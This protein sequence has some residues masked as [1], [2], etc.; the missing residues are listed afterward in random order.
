MST[1]PKGIKTNIAEEL[2]EEVYQALET[3]VGSENV[4]KDPAICQAYARGGY[5]T[6]LYDRE[7]YPPTCVILPQNTEE[8]QAIVKVANRYK[9]P[10][11]PVSTYYITYATPARPN[12]IMMDLKRMNKLITIDEK[13]MYAIVEPY[14][15]HSQIQ[16]EAWKRGL[17]HMSL[18]CGGQASVLAN[19]IF[20]GLGPLGYRI[21]FNGARRLMGTEWV[22]PDGEIV[23][24]GSTSILREYFWG[25]GPGPDLRG[26]LRGL[27]GHCGG[28]GV[29][30][31][32][33]VKLFPWVP[34]AE[35]P[36]KPTGVTPDATLT[37]PQNRIKWYNIHYSNLKNMI[38]AMY[39]ISKA[40]IGAMVHNVAPLW[41]YIP[42]SESATD[43]YDKWS[44]EKE[45]F[46]K[47]GFHFLRVLLVGYTS[48]KQ[49]EYEERV[50][51]EIASETG[52]LRI[53]EAR[54]FDKSWLI[55]SDSLTVFRIAGSELSPKFVFDSLDDAAKL[56]QMVGEFRNKRV[57]PFYDA[58]DYGWI[59]S[60]DLGHMAYGEFLLYVDGDDMDEAGKFE[61]E[62]VKWELE[63]KQYSGTQWPGY[64][65]MLGEK[66]GN[67][68]LLLEKIKKAFDPNNVSNP[69]KPLDLR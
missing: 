49:L 42:R 61:K 45:K 68:H 24:I 51:K 34:A 23:G 22:L 35:A 67:Y 29:I 63:S 7:C 36:I 13:N 31:K 18:G 39:E 56:Q 26:I 16:K 2:P 30:T 40:E 4:S 15:A 53:S 57:P 66:M 32:I 20:S 59:H 37:L 65:R 52:A 10:Y 17:Y 55:G 47:E 19:T 28:L 54:P 25:E 43:L 60:N 9:I 1:I 3:I 6:F 38:D 14:I 21:G 58:L 41:L 8:V 64:H 44:K 27:V 33:G 69:P 48:E 12:A 11:I 46:R 5:G 50:L 62:L